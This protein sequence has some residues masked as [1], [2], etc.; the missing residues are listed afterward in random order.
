M[1]TVLASTVRCGCLN[2]WLSIGSQSWNVESVKESVDLIQVLK[3]C[4][5]YRWIWNPSLKSKTHR[6]SWVD[7]DIP[8]SVPLL[9]SLICAKIVFLCLCH[10][11]IIICLWLDNGVII[12]ECE[13]FHTSGG[14]W[15]WK[16]EYYRKGWPTPPRVVSAVFCKTATETQ[17]LRLSPCVFEYTS[18]DSF[19]GRCAF[20]TEARFLVY[21][22]WPSIL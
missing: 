10:V 1:A 22:T 14:V 4:N 5:S 11:Q 8:F 18:C 13:H 20:T 16:G 19:I 12:N 6:L 7:E 9:R 21:R 17:L 3:W 2:P 15:W